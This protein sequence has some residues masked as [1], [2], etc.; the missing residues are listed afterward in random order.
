[1]GCTRP[2][3]LARGRGTRPAP[4]AGEPH[5]SPPSVAQR[6]P[7]TAPSPVWRVDTGAPHGRG[8][9]SP[10]VVSFETS[11]RPPWAAPAGTAGRGG[12]GPRSAPRRGAERRRRATAPS[13]LPLLTC[14]ARD[15]TAGEPGTGT[16][17]A[18]RV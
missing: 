3:G 11:T 15:G 17:P 9:G 16:V 12:D 2:D 7:G 13:H 14:Q 10:M 5:P 18:R 4:G 8:A 1:L 6:G